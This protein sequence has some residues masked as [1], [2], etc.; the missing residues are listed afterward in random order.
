MTEDETNNKR[1]TFSTT[2]VPTDIELATTIEMCSAPLA[3]PDQNSPEAKDKIAEAPP[4][5][6]HGGNLVEA[7]DEIVEVPSWVA[8]HESF[9]A[10]NHE[11]AQAPP[12]VEHDEIE[13]ETNDKIAKWAC[14]VRDSTAR[15]LEMSKRLDDVLARPIRWFHRSPDNKETKVTE[16]A[17]ERC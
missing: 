17:D 13:V 15:T 16:P 1:A 5:A 11:V 8:Q 4:L 10:A 14:E 7:K 3:E 6:E 9:V 2:L 12:L